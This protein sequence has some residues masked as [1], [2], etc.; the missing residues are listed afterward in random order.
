M[1][2]LY[3]KKIA[4][5]LAVS[6]VLASLWLSACGSEKEELQATPEL[7]TP[8]G[9]NLDTEPVKFGDV[10]NTVAYQAEVMPTTREIYFSVDGKVKSIPVYSGQYVKKGDALMEL[11]Q[12]SVLSQIESYESQLQELETNGEFSDRISDL[13]ISM[14]NIE[15]A[16]IRDRLGESSSAYASKL[17][18][19][20]NEELKKK[21]NRETREIS[22]KDMRDRIEK[23]KETATEQ[24]VYAPCDGY[25]YHYDN[26]SEGSYVNSGRTVCYVVDPSEIKLVVSTESV[27]TNVLANE[28]Y[29]GWIDGERFELTYLPLTDEEKSSYI[30]A[31]QVAPT[32]FEIRGAAEGRIT[33]G[34]TGA[35]IGETYR[36]NDVLYVP[37][38]S[39]LGDGGGK[40]VYVI[41]EGT[42]R[43]KRYVTTGYSNGQVTAIL[44]GLEEGEMVYVEE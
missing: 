13:N 24:T 10:A 25:F 17:L 16:E 27:A 40:F 15:L 18:E 31:K 30:L 28:S 7:L 22:A 1:K 4:A 3:T 5:V 35:V 33:A 37:D 38:A 6:A 42:K 44:E 19:L 11:D 2:T 14:I 39:V 34:M 43:E 21:Q 41:T 20:E 26:I 9:V 36:V 23:L 29:Y 32:V 8:V 12:T